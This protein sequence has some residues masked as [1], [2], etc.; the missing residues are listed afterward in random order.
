M[1]CPRC[2]RE[3][4]AAS[5]RC[6][7]CAAPLGQTVATGLLTPPPPAGGDAPTW[8]LTPPPPLAPGDPPTSLMSLTSLT[9]LTFDADH[10]TALVGAP[11]DSGD[12][13]TAI[14]G[15]VSA[16]ADSGPLVAGQAFGSRYHIIR[17]LG[18]GGMGAV[19]QAWDAELGV[20]VAIKVIRPEVMADPTEAA[21]VERR[22]KRELLLARQVTHKNV[23]RIHD[24]GEINGIKYITMSYVEGADLSTLLKREGTLLVP[25]VMRIAR[26]V[27]SGLVE[28]HKAGV[29]HRDLKPANIMIDRDGDALIMDFGIARSAGGP[30]PAPAPDAAARRLPAGVRRTAV[31]AEATRYGAVMGT[32]EYMAPEQARGQDVDQR[33]DIYAFGLMLYD[34]L[35]GRSRRAERTASAIAELQARMAQAPPPIKSLVPDIPEALDHLVSRC[36]EPDLEKRYQTTEA[37]AIDLDR[38]DENGVPIPIPRRFTPRM[39]AAAAVLVAALVTGTWWLT[40]TPPAPKKHDPV[41][42]LIADFQNQTG[43][44]AFDHTLEQTLRR[45]LEGAGFITALD[46]TKIRAALGVQPP[47]KLDDVAARQ[48]AVKQG[49]GVVLA[50]SIGP[51]G[52]GY[53]ITVKAS[54]PMTGKDIVSV[55]GRASSKDQVLDA[56]TKLVTS[57]RKALGDETSDSAQLLA[58]RTLSTTSL[59]VAARYAAAMEAQSKGK[60]EEALQNYSKAVE[61]DPKF[62]LGYQGLAAMSQNLG[63]LQDS[64]KYATEGLKYLDGMTERERFTTRAAYFLRK[65]DYQQCVKEYGD[66]IA[67]YPADVVAH[68]QRAICLARL[69]KMREAV[70]EMRQAIQIAPKRASYRVNLALFEVYAGDF[71]GA[72]KDVRAMPEPN[73]FAIQALALS[74][75]G[76]G[77]VRDAEET[78][79]RLGTM[80]PSTS[81]AASGLGD[82]ALYEGRFSDAVRIFEEG[83]AADL[84]AKKSDLAAM[85]LTSMAYAQL[86][87]GQRPLAIATAEKALLNSTVVP[88]RLL[89]AR[90][91]VEAGATARARTL[92]GELVAEL[93]AAPQAYGKIIEGEIALKS[94]DARSAITVLTEANG[95]VDTWLGRFDLGRAYLE[96]RAFPQADSEFDQCIARRGEALSLLDEDPTYGYFP[97]VYYY[98]GRV[99]EGLQNAGFATS[100]REYLKIR[101]ESKDD[102]LLPDVRKRAGR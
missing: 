33:A 30:K 68:N 46:R 78:Y 17:A 20:A 27:V 2:G 53:E 102:P 89:A 45:G 32:V 54:Q 101:G 92:A 4:P 82:L 75:L 16:P 9:S 86:M 62:G 40:R 99:R 34:M 14:P 77:L 81:F 29:V 94:G 84:A 88:V 51:R 66:L 36:I 97:T 18:V 93:P 5:E 38:L 26:A 96:A 95:L 47:E 100:Y 37:L 80:A 28:A 55:S 56:A 10:P 59:D 76:R 71:D 91:L 31:T 3:V 21:E 50:G 61:L 22:F 73:P 11:P 15:T 23:V 42:V 44:P 67:R 57:V 43:D 72:D 52:K 98:Q 25:T 6:S 39:I 13:A 1:I 49:L 74:Q 24:L 58:M 90:V 65:D 48:L 19:Y 63:R 85:K 60:Y 69:R 79:R 70:E 41:S 7:R 83:A 12:S 8:L 64:N 35:V 87:R